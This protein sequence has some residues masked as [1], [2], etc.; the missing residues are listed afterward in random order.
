MENI[1]FVNLTPH[2]ITVGNFTIPPSGN[3]ARVDREY[4]FVKEIGWY[5]SEIG[6]TL[7]VRFYR[8]KYGETQG[9]PAPSGEKIFIVSTLVRLANPERTDL[10]SPGELLRDV[11]G[12]VI[13][14]K[15]LE[16]N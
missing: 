14:C 3:Q 16:V 6:K 1:I 9:L 13:G 11:Q 12:A 2:P 7:G 5:D 15:F 10:A 8:G 4:D